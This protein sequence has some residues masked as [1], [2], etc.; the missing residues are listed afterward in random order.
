[1]AIIRILL[2]TTCL[3]LVSSVVGAQ[4]CMGGATFAHNRAQMNANVSRGGSASS[5]GAG[6]SL[7]ATPGPFATLDIGL[8]SA[9]N[10]RGYATVFDG[11]AGLGFPV[12]TAPATEFCPF[13]TFATL[14]GA[15]VL[16][17]H[18]SSL[19]YGAG[20]GLGTRLSFEPTFE[21]VPFVGGAFL[22][23]QST[24][25]LGH[26][27]GTAEDNFFN[28]TFGVGFVI[29]DAF[30]IRPSA[31]YSV[32]HGQ[33]T[34]S[35]ALRVSY[36]FGKVTARPRP[37]T[38]EGSLASV[39]VNPREMIYYCSSSRWYGGTAEGSFMTEREAIAAG[40]GA[41]GGKRC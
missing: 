2:A 18:I 28:A 22:L 7:G 5:G 16:G 15:D 33:T 25:T 23:N 36:S 32:A 30:T 19:S 3:A 31:T 40:Y 26:E 17:E 9:D 39:W 27:G 34:S 35:Y 1:M 37:A 6:A 14:N 24:I 38:G 29:Q 20:L 11:T 12:L 13:F 41:E 21:V 4:T 8:A 10:L